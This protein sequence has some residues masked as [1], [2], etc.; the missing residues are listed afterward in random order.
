MGHRSQ[1]YRLAVDWFIQGFTLRVHA[2]RV[3]LHHLHRSLRIARSCISFKFQLETAL[4]IESVAKVLH[5]AQAIRHRMWWLFPSVLAGLLETV[6]WGVLHSPPQTFKAYEMQIVYTIMG[7]T[8]LAAANF[9]ILGRIINRLS[10]NYSRLS[11]RLY[12]ILFLC[13]DIVSLVVQAIGGGMNAQAVSQRRNPAKGGN[14]I[15]G[16]VRRLTRPPATITAYV[17]CAG[18]FLT[19]YLANR[20][21]R[22][23]ALASKPTP[24]PC[25][26]PR[27][28][29]ERWI[30]GEDHP[31]LDVLDGA[32]I[33]LAI[34]TLNV[35]PT[36]R[37]LSNSAVSTG[38]DA[39]E[40]DD[41]DRDDGKKA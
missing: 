5:V 9:I 10:P 11:P 32:I 27:D 39:A 21:L 4:L 34:F 15:F 36:R 33:A 18:E 3:C 37:L 6:G 35:A 23:S 12:T 20:P 16:E 41:G 19:R 28:R 38:L 31:D 8:P 14:V 40:S 2:H 13:C 25:G 7:P 26:L 29:A 24:S 1:F 17:F 22:A 30:D